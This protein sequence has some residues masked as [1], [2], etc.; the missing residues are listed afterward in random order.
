MQFTFLNVGHGG[1]VSMLRIV[2]IFSVGS[3]PTRRIKTEAAENGMLLDFTAGRKTRSIIVLD[4]K[5]VVLSAV[6]SETLAKGTRLERPEG[7][8]VEKDSQFI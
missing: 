5:Q 8:K 6:N 2:A 7:L 1:F 4:S 3:A